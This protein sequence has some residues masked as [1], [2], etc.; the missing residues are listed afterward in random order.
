M[1][2]ILFSVM[3]AMVSMAS[4]AALSDFNGTYT[5]SDAAVIVKVSTPTPVEQELNVVVT[6][7]KDDSV[8]LFIDDFSFI[9]G[10]TSVPVGDIEVVLYAAPDGSG[11]TLSAEDEINGPVVYGDLYTTIQV[12]SGS[13]SIVDENTRKLAIDL[14]ILGYEDEERTVASSSMPTPADVSLTNA[15]ASIPSS[16][17][18]TSASEVKV[19]PTVAT[20]VINVP[21]NG[22]F[23]I[24]SLAGSSVKSGVV[25]N[26]SVS[27]ADLAAGN[28][29]ISV[30]GKNARFIKK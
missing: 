15:R 2:K 17:S 9:N 23:T 1:K 12:N 27:V 19:Y 4:M 13:L 20:S 16:V 22:E 11:Y 6:R 8:R 28:Y 14:S 3:A 25:S 18:E 5:Q 26:G 10:S 30:N 29:V 24:Y 21:E 7:V